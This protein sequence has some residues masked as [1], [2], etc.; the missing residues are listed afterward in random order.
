[1]YLEYHSRL[2]GEG[3]KHESGISDKS[4]VATSEG[5]RLT[6]SVTCSIS[7]SNFSKASCE[8][9]IFDSKKA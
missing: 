7:D 1:M 4:S 3:V 8:S 2:G 9:R 5:I 6:G